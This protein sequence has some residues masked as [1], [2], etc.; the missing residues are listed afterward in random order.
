MEVGMAGPKYEVTS[1]GLATLGPELVGLR[2][3][4]EGRFLAWA[5]EIGASP[6]LFPALI[7]AD[8]LDKLDYFRNFPHLAVVASRLRPDRLEAYA[9]GAAVAG[10]IPGADLADGR[11]VLPSAA[12]Y[13]IY[14]HL[15]DTALK[16]PRYITT[17]ATCFRN[18]DTFAELQRLW[19]FSMREIV[20]LGTA[21]EVERHL[22][23]FKERILGFASA[24]GFKL[25]VA[26]ASDP[27]YQPGSS[28]ALVQKLFP[29]KEELLYGRALAIGSLNF[30]RN[31]FGERC[32]IRTSDGQPAFTGCVAFGIERWLHALLDRFAGD[33]A[34][35]TAAVTTATAATTA[36]AERK[37]ASR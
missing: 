35:A 3:A 7:R 33:A 32:N 10:G 12:C 20:C 34:A 23:G 19:S 8:R 22:G 25:D 29:Q 37:E 31:F 11:Y 17:V 14:L 9:E 30:H 18:E 28:R 5:A 16:G 21:A 6:M 15:A 1:S 24:L 36:A 27:F 13:G 26:V 4:L 2:A